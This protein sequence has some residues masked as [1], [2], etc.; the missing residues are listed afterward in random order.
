M[1]DINLV[2]DTPI[3][4]FGSYSLLVGELISFLAALLITF[5]IANLTQRAFKRL[6]NRKG[7]MTVTSIYVIGRIIH[8]II[9]FVGFLI[10]LLALGIKLTE[11]ALVASALGVGIGLGLQGLVNNFV[12]GIMILLEKSLKVGDFIELADGMVGEVKEIQMRA[13]LIRTND[14]I[15]VLIPNATLTSGMV[16]NWTL[17][18]NLRRFRIPFSVAYGSDKEIVR[19]AVLE[20]AREVKYTLDI[21]GKEP[22]VWMTGFGDSS[23]NFTL[24]VWVEPDF[25]KHPTSLMSDYLWA[26]DDSFR[27]Y[28]I[29]IP[30]PQ[31]D[32]H[33]RSDCRQDAN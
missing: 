3:F 21:E 22:K 16:T 13:T 7:M 12:S 5:L 18:D 14:N 33:I 9:L 6:A 25:V 28:E 2:L 1:H 19:Q 17:S 26:I 30:F 23:L 11:L 4:K 15:D 31:R 10:S 20:A 27:K 32:L 8:Y 29:E 24:G